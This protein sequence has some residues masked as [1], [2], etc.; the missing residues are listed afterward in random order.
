ME[1]QKLSL[2]ANMLLVENWQLA[3]YWTDWADSRRFFVE[4]NDWSI[5]VIDSTENMSTKSLMEI[6]VKSWVKNAVYM[7]TWMYDMAAFHQPDWKK[8]IMWHNDTNM[9]SNRLVVYSGN[10]E[11][12]VSK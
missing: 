1:T 8:R 2:L 7:D 3:N 9:S 4:Y 6:A 12:K 5:W 11:D 10:S